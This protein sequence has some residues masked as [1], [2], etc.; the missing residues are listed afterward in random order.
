[1][2][3]DGMSFKKAQNSKFRAIQVEVRGTRAR[4]DGRTLGRTD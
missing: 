4:G 1:M 3:A 2:S